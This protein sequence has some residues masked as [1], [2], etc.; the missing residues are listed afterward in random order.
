MYFNNPA[1]PALQLEL[2]LQTPSL[3]QR[4]ASSLPGLSRQLSL[5]AVLPRLLT[6]LLDDA[7]A[8]MAA[9][10]CYYQL[11]TLLAGE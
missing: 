10:L 1:P 9:L 7:A 6:G 5:L 2:E 4:L 3:L 11:P 8:F